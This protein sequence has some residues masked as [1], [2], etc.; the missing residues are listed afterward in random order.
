MEAQHS[1][2]WFRKRLGQIT[3]S[4]VGLLMKSGRNSMFSDTAKSYIY[5]LAAERNMNPDIVNDDEMFEIYLSTVNVES[6]AMRFG[7]EQEEN[8]RDLYCRITGR[9]VVEVGSCGHTEIAHF[10]SSPD[11]FFYDENTGEKGC[12]EIKCP[13]LSVFMKY[14]SEVHD[15]AS[16]LSSK[17]EYFYQCQAHMAC[18]N[19][20]WTDFVV[21]NPFQKY[22]I[23]IVRILPDEKMFSEMEKRIKAA[24]EIIE[25]LI[26]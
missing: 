21:Y 6:K 7:T 10:A 1:L 9:K 20:S 19:A 8:A 17:P 22:P 15:N 11:G 4:Q 18:V 12:L 14:K 16:L 25:N 13:S 24:N 26:S 5:Q 2:E 23:H 3:G